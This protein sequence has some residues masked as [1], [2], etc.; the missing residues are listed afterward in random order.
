MAS[1]VI[2]TVLGSCKQNVSYNTNARFYKEVNQR[3]AALLKK[4]GI[5]KLSDSSCL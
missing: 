3:Y 5:C 1:Q 2:T 4:G